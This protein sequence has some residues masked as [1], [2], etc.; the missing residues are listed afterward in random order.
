MFNYTLL[1]G[2]ATQLQMKNNDTDVHLLVAEHVLMSI[3][4]LIRNFVPAHEQ[5][6]KGEWDVASVGMLSRQG[7][8]SEATY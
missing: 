5:I 2:A 6:V 7:P 1:G 8:G 3:L 4:V